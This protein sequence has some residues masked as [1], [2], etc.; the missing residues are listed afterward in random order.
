MYATKNDITE[1]EKRINP[2]KSLLPDIPEDEFLQ[3]IKRSKSWA[4][5]ARNGSKDKPAI[6]RR[7]EWYVLNG[8][9]VH[10]KASGVERV[11]RLM[12]NNN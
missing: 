10:Y 4:R 2:I 7:S 3:L 12:K 8:K 6:F 9:N 11:I 5:K 1:L